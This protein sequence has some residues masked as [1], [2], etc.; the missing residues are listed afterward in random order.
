MV[1]SK[2]HSIEDLTQFAM[3]VI[4]RSRDEALSYYG[5]GNPHVKFDEELVT[6]AELHL[7]E[8][9]QDQL[10]A[11]FPEHQVFKNNQEEKAYTHEENTL[12]FLVKGAKVTEVEEEKIKETIH[13]IFSKHTGQPIEKIREDTERDFFMSSEDALE[14]GIIDKVIT[15]REMQT[16][17]KK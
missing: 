17:S 15:E 16:E 9:F 2:S 4:H 1:F 11:H 7:R 14:Y 5:K 8:F 3:E 10:Q 13:R 12:N 6:E